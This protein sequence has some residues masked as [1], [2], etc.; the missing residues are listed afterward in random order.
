MELSAIQR[1]TV[2]SL[3][4]TGSGRPVSSG[5]AGL[6]R[7]RIE[8]GIRPFLP[9]LRGS[10][11]LP[12]G[13][14]RLAKERLN[15][16][17]RCEGLFH[18]DLLGERAPFVHS[19]ASAAGTLAHKSIELDV[20]TA[21]PAEPPALAELAAARL[22]RD[23][24]FGPYWQSLDPGSQADLRARAARSVEQFRTSFPPIRALRR[25]LAPVS[26]QWLE[27]RFGG[28]ALR[29]VGKV[30]LLL[31]A[32]RGGRSTRVLIDLKRGRPWAEHAED[33]RLYALLHT[34]RCG[35]PPYRVATFF[36]S[37]GEWQPEDVTEETLHHAAQRV[38]EGVAA[39]ARLG[40][41]TP[42][43]RPGRHCVRCPRSD[44]CPASAVQP[45]LPGRLG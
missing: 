24:Q 27:A 9:A 45:D 15:E 4:D 40:E 13:P 22:E 14:L 12:P 25:R 18:A 19:D 30:D 34:F 32:A 2:S 33:M 16:L 37:S 44:T 1:R 26:E 39:A 7:D 23:R 29:V 17:A 10:A 6:L 3:L 21:D 31:N 36:L 38:I 20:A 41:G 5:L 35:I 8:E 28:G 43:L 42:Q 11:R